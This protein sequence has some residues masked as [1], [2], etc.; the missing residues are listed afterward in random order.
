VKPA[1]RNKIIYGSL[2]IFFLLILGWGIALQFMGNHTGIWNYGYNLGYAAIYL[3]GGLVGLYGA[4]Y[5][6]TAISMGMALLYLGAAQISY[7]LGLIVWAYYN[8]IA[9]VSVPYPSVADIFFA[10]FYILLAVGCW[11]FLQMVATH[12]QV[13]YA[14]EVLAIFFVS[15]VIIIGFLN[16]PD[17]S[18]GVGALAKIFNIWYPLGDSLLISLS[19]IVYRA[20]RDKFQSGV[21]ILILGLLI[22]VFADLIFSYRTS[23]NAYWNG[24]VS[25]ILFAVSGFVLSLGILTIFY[26]FTTTDIPEKDLSGTS[27]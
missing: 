16:T 7:A 23:I 18:T 10:L 19:Y 20:G 15:A 17:S 9:H 3:I 22:Q 5:V 21:F 13:Q 14:F 1:A 4:R 6:T 27:P 11:N 12:V 2:I 26:N 24:D 8:L 25:D